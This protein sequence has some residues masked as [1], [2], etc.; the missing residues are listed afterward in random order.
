MASILNL[1]DTPPSSPSASGP[2]NSLADQIVAGLTGKR[3]NVPGK[4]EEDKEWSY[5]KEIP[6]GMYLHHL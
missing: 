2:Q 1:R 6:T 5:T 3:Q 4:R